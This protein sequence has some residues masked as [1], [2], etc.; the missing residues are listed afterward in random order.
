MR[1][2]GQAAM[3][4][5]MTYGWAILI[6]IVVIGALWKMGV[7]STTSTVTC[8]PCFSYFAYLD[9]SA[10]TLV[11]RN[12]GLSINVTAVS[13]GSLTGGVNQEF[14]AGEDLTL[15][16]LATSGDFDYTVTYTNVESGLSHTDTAKIH[17]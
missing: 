3:E 15:T 7:F 8:S 11:V 10:G 4:Y 14:D 2:K 6:I 5:L 1:K 16:G 17:N 9:Y 12:G 13:S